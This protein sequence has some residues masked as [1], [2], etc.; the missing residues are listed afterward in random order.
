VSKTSSFHLHD[1]ILFQALECK[2]Y[3][4]P[5]SQFDFDRLLQLHT[6]DKTEKDKGMSYEHCKVVDYCKEKGDDHSSNHT[7]LLE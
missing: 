6:L 3:M 7:C 2:V 1:A 4:N 5:K